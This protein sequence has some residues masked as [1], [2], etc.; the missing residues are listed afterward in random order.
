M[1]RKKTTELTTQDEAPRYI[2]PVDITELRSVVRQATFIEA[3]ALNGTI[4]AACRVAKLSR[5][6]YYRLSTSHWAGVVNKFYDPV[7]VEACAVA[8]T[9]QFKDVVME[10]GI[11][12]AVNG[13]VDEHYDRSGLITRKEHKYDSAILQLL[14]KKVDPELREQRGAGV[15]VDA[16]TIV[17]T[18]AQAGSSAALLDDMSP[19]EKRLLLAMNLARK[20]RL[21]KENNVIEGEVV[22]EN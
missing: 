22:T 12:R 9:E 3:L 8:I 6:W 4:S 14:M 20:A 19:E 10:A 1:T 11:D 17:T 21:E 2:Q 18:A 13:W 5:A 15:V 16:R 7:F